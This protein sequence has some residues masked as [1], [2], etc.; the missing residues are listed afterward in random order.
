MRISI[1]DILIYHAVAV[2]KTATRT[3]LMSLY[4]RVYRPISLD[5]LIRD[6]L[7]ATY[8]NAT[9]FC[10]LFRNMT[11]VIAMSLHTGLA[12]DPAYLGAMDVDFSDPVHLKFFRNSL[13]EL[14]RIMGRQCSVFYAMGVNEDPDVVVREIFEEH[15][16]QVNYEDMGARGT[17]FDNY[18]TLDHFRRIEDFRR[19]FAAFGL[20]TDVVANLELTLEELHPKLFDCLASAA[21]AVERA[22]TEEDLAQAALSGR[23]LLE[24][25]ADYLFPPRDGAWNGRKVGSAQ[26]KNRLWAYIENVIN[27]AHIDDATLLPELGKEADRLIQLFNEGLHANL[28]RQNVEA[29]F[30]DLTLWLSMVIELDPQQA[31]KPYLA[32]WAELLKFAE[33]IAHSAHGREPAAGHEDR[34]K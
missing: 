33:N 9:V 14:C 2:S 21:R 19:A 12:P 8:G 27:E 23:R 15:G 32:Y 18:D 10:W 4:R 17:I 6:R 1:G 26:Y 31:R 25:I 5:L 34:D 20:G 16:F 11:R 24:R 13:P 7:E 29:A 3:D 28:T 30:R 22:E